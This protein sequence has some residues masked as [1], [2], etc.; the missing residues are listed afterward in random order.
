MD[1]LVVA[2]LSLALGTVAGAL[3]MSSRSRAAH[4]AALQ[5]RAA[6]AAALEA[7][8]RAAAEKIALLQN[9]EVT[10]R[11]AF[12]AL[13]SQ[14]LQ[15]NSESFLRL[16][17]T[18][19]G[20]FQKSATM[21]LEGRH[22]A[23]DS[24][25]GP[26]RESLH[27]VDAKLVDVDR[28]RA[29]SQAQLSEQLRSLTQAQQVLHS[30]TSKLSRALRSSNIRGQWG[31]IQ[32]RRVL[33][34]A[35]LTE[36]MHF[37]LKESVRTDE[38]RLTPDAVIKLPGGKNVV[39]DAKVALSAYLDAMDCED[40]PTRDAKLR[41]HAR[42]VK[43]H[44]NQ[45]GNKSY[46]MHFQPAPD[47]VVMFVPGEALLSTALQHDEGLLEFSMN[48]GVMLASPL[49]LIALL[50][51]IAYG[52]QQ[53]TIAKN[54]LEISE[55]GRNLYD[56]IAKLAD[57]FENVGRSL[58]KAVQSY[59]GAVGTLETRVLVTA[60]K[61]KDKGVTASEEFR[62]VETIDI[63]P[64]LLGAPELVGLFDDV[65]AEAEILPSTEPV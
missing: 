22:K 26:L 29:S 64:R 60:R 20:E 7:E 53:D 2:L 39:V 23:I 41:E 58:A 40:D 25:I 18:S 31:E 59:N 27:K 36:G 4:E 63:T 13:S 5:E 44:V 57:H 46:W 43:D 16:A 48:K 21:D 50:K 19:L 8:R 55:L 17:R 14:A 51:A 37:D 28:G 65:P 61:L 45:L 9:A 12:S 10:L 47:I 24:L 3:W 49:T 52:W 38:G 33:E 6:L 54:A 35:G 42:Q 30:E 34:C 11:D 32:L 56:R 1:T 15:A 62:E